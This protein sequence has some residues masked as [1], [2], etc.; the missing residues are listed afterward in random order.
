MP[1]DRRLKPQQ[2][3]GQRK[4]EIRRAVEKLVQGIATGKIKPRVGAQG[5]IA[6][7]GFD[8]KDRDGMTDN[9]AY[10]RLLASGS[11]LVLAEL[12]RAE[13][14]AGRPVDKQVIGQGVHSHD[15]GVNWH[16]HKG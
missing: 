4:E 7:Q 1:C 5:A 6:F 3:I 9:C 11:S 12:A 10:R 13:A 16:N 15:G 14:I 2:T 8:P